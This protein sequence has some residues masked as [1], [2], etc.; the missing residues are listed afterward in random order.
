M[1]GIH[2]VVIVGAGFAGLAAALEL[3]AAGIDDVVMIERAGDVGGT[4]RENV[5]PGVACD[6]PSALY[7]LRRHPSA[8]WS[9]EFAPGAE[10]QAYL[11]RVAAEHAPA[12]GIRF[13]TPLQSAR[14][15]GTHWELETPTGPL[16]AHNLVLACGRLTEPALPALPGLAGFPGRVVHS[17]RWDTDWDVAGEHIAVVGT[18]ASGIQLVPELVR[19][20]ARVTLFQRSAA[21]ILPRG[22]RTITAAERS[23]RSGDREALDA[24]RER[25]FRDGETRF[26]SRAGDAAAA[27][28]A[29]DQAL[30]HLHDSVAGAELRSALT[31]DYAFGCK[32]VLLS[33]DFYPAVASSAVTLEPTA[34]AH[35]EGHELVAASGRRHRVDAVVLATG[36]HAT[37]Q[38]YATLVHGE[39]GES[40]DE[41]WSAGMT[42]ALSTV[43]AGFP[44]LF[45][46]NGPNAAL[47]HNSSIL[48]LEEQAGYLARVIAG[49]AADAV[50]RVDPAAEESYTALIQQRAATTSW[51]TGGCSSWYVDDRS[52]RLT[53]LWPGT[54]TDFRALLAAADGSEFLTHPMTATKKVPS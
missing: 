33:D 52:G 43:V 31:P 3:R 40:L 17:A 23:R 42:S 49:G 26:A 24:E 34:L 11:R 13:H 14:W 38:A 12:G 20:G 53:L 9:H 48:M 16:R 29:T 45:V 2:Q 28:A 35:V 54:V 8:R 6:V 21:W 15:H 37:R 46:L 39:H 10:I 41:H 51:I 32:R 47:G 1:T 18:G 30:A 19:R 7:A 27:A 44:N 5:Y 25:L 50:R 36:F 22:G 4:W